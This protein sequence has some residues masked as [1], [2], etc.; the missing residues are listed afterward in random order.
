MSRITNVSFSAGLI[1]ATAVLTT[2]TR[3]GVNESQRRI[4]VAY[5]TDVV[6]VGGSTAA[7]SAAVAA[8]E[9]GAKVFLAAQRPY[10]GDDMTATLRLWLEEGETPTTELAKRLF[11][12]PLRDARKLDTRPR[13]SF[14]YRTSLPSATAHPDSKPA[15]KLFDG[16]YQN[17]VN[18]SVQYDGDVSID[19][20]LGK[21]VDVDEI[22]VLAF[23]R[24][25][26]AQSSGFSVG[27]IRLST[28]QNAA[29][30][31]SGRFEKIAA[32]SERKNNGA[33]HDGQPIMFSA[34]V[35]RKARFLRL[36]VAKTQDV[37]RILLGE[38]EVL[39]PKPPAD[40]KE[41]GPPIPPM[42]RPMHVKKTLDEVL[43]EAGVTF[44][45]SCY[46]TD[47]LRDEAGNV[48]GIVMA[49]RAGRQAVVAKVVVDATEEGTVARMAGA[50]FRRPTNTAKTKGKTRTFRRT[51]IG[52][53]PIEGPGISHRIIAPPF[54][55][56][57]PNRARTSS[58]VF[59]VIEYTLELPLD[60]S[61]TN[62]WV[63]NGR[64]F[65]DNKFAALAAADQAAR[66]MTYHPEQQFTS[67]SLFYIGDE[68][69][70]GQETLQ[71]NWPGIASIPLGV[72]RPTG[73]PRL[74]VAGPAADVP[75]RV[76]EKLTRPLARIDLGMRLGQ[77]AAE[78]AKSLPTSQGVQL[79]GKKADN[80]I[81]KG[82]T[83]EIL[84][85]VRPT[86]QLDTIVQATRDLPVLGQ[87][88]VV[89]IGGGT[90]GAPAGI[91]AARAGAKTLVVEYLHGL[92]GVGTMGAISNYY[93]GNRVGF[94]K[95]V[96]GGRSSWV[97]EQKM[98]W[99]RKELQKAGADVWFGTVGCGAFVE[100]NEGNKCVRGA[101]VVTPRGRGVVLAKVVI[102]ATGNAD[103]A[104]AAGAQ[105]SYVDHS[106]FAM[107]GTGL[108]PRRLGAS[109]T[110]TDW[111]FSDETDIVDIWRIFVHG[112]DK[113]PEAFD[114]GQLIDT[115][116]RRR[117]VGDA[118]ITVLDQITRRT[119]P[120]SIVRACSDFDSHG[121]TIDPYLM[122]EHPGRK[123]VYA[124]VPYRCLLPRGIE[125]MLVA[126]IA[127]SAHRDALP[128]TRMQPD[129]QNQ[130]YA[131]GRAAA[132]AAADNVALRKIDIK[133]LQKHLVEIGNLPHSVLT[134][135]DSYP[136]SAQQIA[137]AVE[138][139][140]HGKKTAAVILAHPDQARPLLKEAYRQAKKAGHPSQLAYAKLLC[141]FGESEAAHTVI[142]A[143]EKHKQWDAGW[144]FRGLGQYG[145][146]LSPLDTLIVTLGHAGNKD[147]LPAIFEKLEL[148]TAEHD[149]SHHRAVGLAFE[150]IGDPSAAQPLARLLSKPDMQGYAHTSLQRVRE[151][152]PTTE[153][154]INAIVSRRVSL[155]E[156]VIARA[157][158]RCGDHNGLGRK[159]LTQY[160]QDLRGHFARHAKAVL[161]E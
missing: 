24:K 42:P 139:I 145:S 50:D 18:Q 80:A 82:D 112:K 75:R 5:R 152:D 78:E 70:T 132:M 4:P 49:N 147:A 56:V 137:A 9:S 161:Q 35:G 135:Q 144:N 98:E 126:G 45:Y 71:G 17:P 73:L 93:H 16:K 63:F 94:T 99:Y 60:G 128:V 84:V 27:R 111:T 148:L 127:A 79:P 153:V 109:Y 85:G 64:N 38:I 143:V 69:I 131:A 12:D 87:Y 6:V 57:F 123:Q 104:A 3:A 36:D 129:I 22:C 107:Q 23:D 106:E 32:V 14:S 2:A 34:A 19:I 154:G 46:P 40:A 133:K 97:I 30:V 146:A 138:G 47:V 7:V 67:D 25:T 44:L 125:G 39:G 20:D 65:Q 108:P 11:N 134:D 10:L 116:E 13:L 81:A 114:Q 58:G 110:N 130:G 86:Q 51:V 68:R 96:G 28:A 102:D 74:L 121:F 157:L 105:C 118:T 113:Y 61:I 72:F 119:F 136:M 100:N 158:F 124:Y 140:K 8:A 150:M 21:M 120:D 83:T 76:A 103:V 33:A 53:E 89:V 26:T 31:K 117:I 62:G 141:V 41:A 88:D 156:L 151:L 91:A 37:E 43:L 115:R 54:I 48:C 122:L 59:N 101:V 29:D 155:R 149:F 92:G 90:A 142:A 95:E 66:R 160:A 77:A 52:G 159:I 55:G 1:L 15:A